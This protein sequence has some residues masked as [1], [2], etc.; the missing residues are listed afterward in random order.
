MYIY[1]YWKAKTEQNKT[2]NLN[3]EIVRSVPAY[4]NT[5]KRCMFYLYEK[6]LI[7]TYPNQEDLLNKRSELVS[8]CQHENKFLLKNF[9]SGD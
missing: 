4:S 6:L 5:T 1:I 2:P 3:W 8:K 9:K 7:A